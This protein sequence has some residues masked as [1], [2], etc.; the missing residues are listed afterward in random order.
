MQHRNAALFP[1]IA[2]VLG[3]AGCGQMIDDQVTYATWKQSPPDAAAL[4]AVKPVRF[5]V[6]FAGNDGALLCTA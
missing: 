6:T 4:I 5:D 3:L 1:A 2:L